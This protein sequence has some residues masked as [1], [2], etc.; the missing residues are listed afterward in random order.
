[1]TESVLLGNIPLRVELREEL[2][3]VKL[4]WDTESLHFPNHPGANAFL[5][6]PYRSGW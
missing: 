5:R 3:K 4:R 2:T 6:R 1:L